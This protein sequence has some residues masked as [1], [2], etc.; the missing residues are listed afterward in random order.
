MI[1]RTDQPEETVEPLDRLHRSGWASAR[2]SALRN[3]RAAAATKATL[4]EAERELARAVAAA[5]S[6]TT[7]GVST[8]QLAFLERPGL[9]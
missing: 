6:G 3:T 9:V 7:P 5:L 2:V 4:P 8:A 1:D